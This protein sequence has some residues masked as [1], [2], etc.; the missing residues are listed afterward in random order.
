MADEK[1][2][3]ISLE[4]LKAFE[5]IDEEAPRFPISLLE[6]NIYGK[7]CR[8]A[9]DA[10]HIG[11]P[12]QGGRYLLDIAWLLRKEG[13]RGGDDV[14]SGLTLPADYFGIRTPV[15][16]RGVVAVKNTG[17]AVLTLRSLN[18]SWVRDYWLDMCEV[19]E[20]SLEVSSPFVKEVADIGNLQFT[21]YHVRDFGDVEPHT[22]LPCIDLK[23]QG[24]REVAKGVVAWSGVDPCTDGRLGNAGQLVGNGG[25]ELSC[26]DLYRCGSSGLM[27]RYGLIDAPKEGT[28]GEICRQAH[29]NLDDDRDMV[30]RALSD[31]EISFRHFEPRQRRH[32]EN[33]HI[34]T[35]DAEKVF[36]DLGFRTQI[37]GSSFA[38]SWKGAEMIGPDALLPWDY[39]GDMREMAYAAR[40]LENL[41]SPLRQKPFVYRR[42]I[43]M[44][45]QQDVLER[46]V[47]LA[48]QWQAEIEEASPSLGF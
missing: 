48:A 31:L 32:H 8:P 22:P 28:I 10:M 41:S 2:T 38:A 46:F 33:R 24:V 18:G 1:Q 23:E 16:V 12:A 25:V 29:D 19:T 20:H 5:P 44:Q 43:L 35:V 14:V 36:R 42:N 6:R 3:D 34:S 17:K 9:G 40:L 27:F 11:L 4:F 15:N 21:V 45:V 26:L 47:P 39:E 37:H 30:F 13:E 7:L